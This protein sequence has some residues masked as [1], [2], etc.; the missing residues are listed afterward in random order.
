MEG[1]FQNFSAKQNAALPFF[2]NLNFFGTNGSPVKQKV[3]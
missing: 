2:Q 3:L 1:I